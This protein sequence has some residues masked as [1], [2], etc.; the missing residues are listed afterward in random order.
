MIP[1]E[2]CRFPQ[3]V[4]HESEEQE[5]MEAIGEFVVVSPQHGQMM[6][7]ENALLTRSNSAM[8]SCQIRRLLSLVFSSA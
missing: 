1:F 5:N 8:S 7:G 6:A 2:S 4:L 3:R